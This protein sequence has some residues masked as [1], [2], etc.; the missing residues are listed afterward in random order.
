MRSLPCGKPYL[1][2]Q[3]CLVSIL[4]LI[5][6]AP[7][8]QDFMHACTHTHLWFYMWSGEKTGKMEKVC[9]KHFHYLCLPKI[10]VWK[11]DFRVQLP[12]RSFCFIPEV[13]FYY[14]ISS[15]EA[16]HYLGPL[17]SEFCA[18]PPKRVIFKCINLTKLAV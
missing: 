4:L 8:D 12:Q 13:V 17:I 7:T 14:H 9:G 3:S 11:S 15:C 10:K 2:P 6:M 18:Y 5:R 1:P 16:F